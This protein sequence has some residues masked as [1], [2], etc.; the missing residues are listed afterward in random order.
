MRQAIESLRT[1]AI[2]LL[3]SG[4]TTTN[5]L[6][7]DPSQVHDLGPDEGIVFGSLLVEIAPEGVRFGRRAAGSDYRLTISPA[8]G[9]LE[10]LTPSAVFREEFFDEEWELLMSPGEERT[11]VAR[12]P[13]GYQNVGVLRLK[14]KS[15]WATSGEFDINARFRVQGRS[16]TY[17]GRLVLVLPERLLPYSTAHVRI[18]DSLVRDQVA[19]GGDYGKLFDSPRVELINVTSDWAIYVPDPPPPVP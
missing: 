12:L 5:P 15:F 14:P 3:M 8:R 11:F 16:V 1:L 6:N 2:A 10:A 18:E 4:C 7:V 17:I 19:L 9:S 13:S